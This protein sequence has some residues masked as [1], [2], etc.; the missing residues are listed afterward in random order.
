MFRNR[1]GTRF[2]DAT[3]TSGSGVTQAR[4]SR[5]AAFGD[6]DNDGDVDV[7]V[8]TMNEPPALLRN[9]Y[10]GSN[11][12]VAVQLEGRD[13]NRSAIGATVRVTVAGARRRRPC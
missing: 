11:R 12:W 9:D 1:D 4:S 5:G 8:M 2:D 10:G 13:S 7:L 3:A 6:F